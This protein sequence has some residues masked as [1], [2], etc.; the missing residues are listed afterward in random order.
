MVQRC[1][2]NTCCYDCGQNIILLRL[3]RSCDHRVG[4]VVWWTREGRRRQGW[5]WSR[6]VGSWEISYSR[7]ENINYS[8]EK[9]KEFFSKC[10]I[11]MKKISLGNIFSFPQTTSSNECLT[12]SSSPG[13]CSRR[14]STVSLSGWMRCAGSTWTSLQC[15]VSSAACWLGRSKRYMFCY[16]IMLIYSRTF[17]P[18]SLISL[19]SVSISLHH[20]SFSPG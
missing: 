11:G 1:W 5:E 13:C 14:Q 20:I 16:I 15:C 10:I 8:T 12:S 17:I 18:S 9:W 6:L 4:G 7:L 19:L 3:S 2:I